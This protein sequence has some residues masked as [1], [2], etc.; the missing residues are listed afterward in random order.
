M[1]DIKLILIIA[2]LFFGSTLFGAWLDKPMQRLQSWG[3]AEHIYLT[4]D[5]QYSTSSIPT[6]KRHLYPQYE[7]TTSDSQVADK[8]W[9]CVTTTDPDGNLIVPT[10]MGTPYL[11][12]DANTG[13]Q[14]FK[15]CLEE[16]G[17][18]YLW[19]RNSTTTAEDRAKGITF[20]ITASTSEQYWDIATST[21]NV[22]LG[23]KLGNSATSSPCWNMLDEGIIWPGKIWALAEYATSVVSVMESEPN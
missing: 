8:T 22:G 3:G 18:T 1:R 21:L 4:Q 12:S 16:G 13:R 15:A 7:A 23:I 9:Y 19:F 2:A 5:I 20:P 10:D 11:L 6:C 14:Y 17:E